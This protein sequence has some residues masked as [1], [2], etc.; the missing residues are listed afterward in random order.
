MRV[1]SFS[2]RA[3]SRI[4]DL[5]ATDAEIDALNEAAAELAEKPK[6]GYLLPF[7]N[8]EELRRYDA[9]RFGLIYKFD[10]ERLDVVTVVG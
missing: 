8:P 1:Y 3:V 6:R 10:E 4:S 5:R 9:G 7:F 2:P